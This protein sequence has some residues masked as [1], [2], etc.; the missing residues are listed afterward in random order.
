MKLRVLFVR[1]AFASLI[2]AWKR[3]PTGPMLGDSRKLFM[4]QVIHRGGCLTVFA[5]VHPSMSDCRAARNVLA[6][7]AHLF[8]AAS[9]TVASS[10]AIP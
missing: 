8:L 1:T 9:R 4:A 7:L 5:A 3:L 10:L 2:F 6:E